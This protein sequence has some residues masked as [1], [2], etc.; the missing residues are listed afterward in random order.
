MQFEKE[1]A[2]LLKSKFPQGLIETNL[3]KKQDIY[4]I[5][6]IWKNLEFLEQM[7]IKEKPAAI[8]LFEK[9]NTKPVANVYQIVESSKK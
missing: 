3:L 4:I 1:Y 9:F 8:I 5:Q 2:L 6:S 7:R